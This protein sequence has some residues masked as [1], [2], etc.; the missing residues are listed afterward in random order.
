MVWWIDVGNLRKAHPWKTYLDWE[1]I[2]KSLKYDTREQI[3]HPRLSVTRYSP[4]S[5]TGIM[6]PNGGN[7]SC[8][9][10]LFFWHTVLQR[11]QRVVGTS[12]IPLD[13]CFSLQQ[14]CG[15]T[16]TSRQLQTRSCTTRTSP[17]QKVGRL[18]TYTKY[19]WNQWKISAVRPGKWLTETKGW[20]R[21]HRASWWSGRFLDLRSG[22]AQ[23]DCRLLLLTERFCGVIGTSRQSQENIITYL[24][25]WL[26][27]TDLDW[28]IWSLLYNHL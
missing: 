10:F 6:Q 27:I 5:S 26:I 23:F 19:A 1:Y 18:T 28:M 3:T 7:I 20:R 16:E 4:R 8:W 9:S 13:C 15:F 24:W 12:L 17:G 11:I 22:G 21:K 2:L 14:S 25:S